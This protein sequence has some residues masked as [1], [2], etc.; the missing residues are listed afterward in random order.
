M[1]KMKWEKSFG[2][3]KC[4]LRVNV[5]CSENTLFIES[6]SWFYDNMKAALITNYMPT[7]GERSG[8]R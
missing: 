5:F 7:W 8:N 4:E 6:P 1:N 3:K 2:H